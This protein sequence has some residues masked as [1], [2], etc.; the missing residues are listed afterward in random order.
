VYI[1][2]VTYVIMRS[3]ASP[4]KCFPALLYVLE[5]CPLRKSDISSLD[6]VVNRFFMKL[7]QTNN[8]DIVNYCRAQFELDLPSTIVQKRSKKFVAK[9]RSYENVTGICKFA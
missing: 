4:D 6:S 8:I 3:H 9:Y 5:V 2:G 1:S 7:F